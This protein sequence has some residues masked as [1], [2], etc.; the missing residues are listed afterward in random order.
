MTNGTLSTLT[1]RFAT[2]REIFG[3]TAIWRRHAASLDGW[4]QEIMSW[5]EQRQPDE[6]WFCGA[7]T[8][9]FIGEA[10]ARHL[11]AA[12]GPAR[13][14][15]VASTDLVSTP[16]QF[17]RPNVRPLVVSFGRSGNSPESH[18]TVTLLNALCPE[19]DRLHITCNAASELATAPHPGPGELRVITLPPE[20]EDSGFAMT[21]SYTT[22]LLTALACFDPDGTP[23]S[24]RVN[25]LADAADGYLTTAPDR[26]AA[27]DTP[28]RVVFL[29]SGALTAVA[30]EAALKVLELT[31]GRIVTAW[32][33]SLGFRHGPKA[34]MTP[35]TL[36]C[37]FPSSDPHTRAYD[38][39]IASEIARE[40]GPDRIT[41]AK[42][43]VLTGS[44]CWD[45]VLYIL[46]A[47]L[48]ALIWSARLGISVDDPFAGRN[49]SRVV[50]GV[51]L[52]DPPSPPNAAPQ[53]VAGIDVGGTKIE[54]VL[55]GS[56][57]QRLAERRIA[58]CRDDYATFL[59]Q[60]ETESRWLADRAGG[61]IPLGIG[62]PGI[63]VDRRGLAFTA[64]L[65]AMGQPLS[66][67]LAARLGRVVALV[68]DCKAFALSEA[69]GGAGE[70]F[71]TVFGLII[72]TGVGGGLVVDGKLATGL[73]GLPG[74]VGHIGIP[75]ALLAALKLPTPSCG[76]G[77][78]GCYETLASGPGLTRILAARTGRILSP[79]DIVAASDDEAAAA[80]EAWLTIVA[81]LLYTLQLTCDPEVIVL[82]GGLSRIEGIAARLEA[83]YAR[84][85]MNNTRVAAI[86]VARFGDASGARGAALVAV[87]AFGK[88]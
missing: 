73:N 69:R 88:E 21:S 15:A 43:L 61:P 51:R 23:P 20:S 17:L 76:C 77:R 1:E 84:R 27:L 59:D 55:F 57:F 37:L 45:S 19:A 83:A 58:V 79:Q 18:G 86:R 75:A 14:R 4:R 36:V 60:L 87:D 80:F 68:N 65:P 10:V 70:G 71:R 56:D 41:R 9:A 5:V 40:Y 2:A 24:E 66:R 26:I 8:S 30:R 34:V 3:Q 33:S 11:N 81:E 35:S 7:G 63:A 78:L 52:Y 29:G 67:D 32:D 82:G 28:D 31:A 25:R 74:E 47:Q 6:I 48:C 12:P 42:G 50:S 85:A 13:F 72:G 16:L 39:D 22:M 54:S 38:E 46:T 49:L 62:M 53:L 64:N 44:D